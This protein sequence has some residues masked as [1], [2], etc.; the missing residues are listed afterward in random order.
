MANLLWNKRAHVERLGELIDSGASASEAARALGFRYTRNA[1]LGK[2]FRMGWQFGKVRTE[3][4]R[5]RV[6]HLRKTRHNRGQPKLIG[7][8]CNFD[9]DTYEEIVKRATAERISIPAVI[10]ELV[11]WGMEA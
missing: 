3:E 9:P 2:A 1:V 7:V 8:G 10:R 4:Q 6:D 11:E 5:V